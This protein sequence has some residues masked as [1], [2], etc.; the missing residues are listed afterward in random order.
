MRI[1]LDLDEWPDFF[2]FL[3]YPDPEDRV[4]A[5]GLGHRVVCHADVFSR[6]EP[7]VVPDRLEAL[8]ERLPLV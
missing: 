1:G 8:V 7:W 3:T 6:Y 2:S 4:P 5:R